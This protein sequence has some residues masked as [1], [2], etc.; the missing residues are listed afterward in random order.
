MNPKHTSYKSDYSQTCIYIRNAFEYLN[1]GQIICSAFKWFE[2]A[3]YKASIKRMIAF[4]Y[5]TIYVR[6]SDGLWHQIA[7]VF[8]AFK[9]DLEHTK[10]LFYQ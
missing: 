2:L 1:T 3:N 6:F 7:T 10:P 5:R 8:G 4:E 9:S